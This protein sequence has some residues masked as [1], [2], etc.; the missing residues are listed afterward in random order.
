MK[1]NFDEI[2][3]RNNT[4]SLNIEGFRSYIFH[5]EAD[6][7]FP[8]KDEDFIRMWVA[9]ME[10]ATPDVIINEIKKRLDKKIFGY[11]KVFDPNYYET[12]VS[13]T[14]KMYDWTFNR[15][16]LV[17]SHG[18]V[19]ALYELVGYICKEEEEV[20]FFTP[21]YA[22]FQYSSDFNHRKAITSQL[23]VDETGYYT[24]DFEDFESK[25]KNNNVKLC[26]FCNPHNP[27]GRVWSEEELYRVGKICKDNNVLIISDE[28]HCD[29]LRTGLKHI[30]LAKVFPES[31]DIITCMAASKTF[32]LAGFM[33]SNIIIPNKEVMKIW[34]ARHHADENPISIVAT[35]AAFAYGYDWLVELK[36][37][38]DNNFAMADKFIKENLPKA[39]FKIPEATYLGW[40]NV[41]AYLEKGT[42]L[43]LFFA[44]NAGVLL[45]AE[46]MFVNN[47]DGYIRLNLACPKATLIEGLIRISKALNNKK[48]MEA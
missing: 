4:N 38:L 39:I 41:S 32:N 14:S 21:S 10:F 13:W 24:I 34:Q 31:E 7:K 9:D 5:A 20:I 35:Q 33:F 45:E 47:A 29:L 44:N 42:N 48:Q 18:I 23:K 19:P 8:Y 3:D 15:E 46:N 16:Q 28:I 2:I 26:I 40:V 17:T 25:V 27:S 36:K 6:M 30:P 12:I 22:Y 37:Y 1:Y 11:T 43:P